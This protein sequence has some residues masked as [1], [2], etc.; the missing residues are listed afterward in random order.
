MDKPL[1]VLGV[2]SDGRYIGHTLLFVCLVASAFTLKKREYGLFA[3]FGGTLHLLSDIWGF[4]PWFYPFKSYDFPSVDFHGIVTWY[5]VAFTLIELAFAIIV[6]SAVVSVSLSSR[7]RVG[8]RCHPEPGSAT[9][10][11]RSADTSQQAPGPL[12]YR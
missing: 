9:R 10:S 4:M 11:D 5:V 7:S 6:V 3:L 12:K 1:W 8:V 2:I